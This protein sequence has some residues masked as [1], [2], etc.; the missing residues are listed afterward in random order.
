[1]GSTSSLRSNRSIKDLKEINPDGTGEASPPSSPA[2][3][4]PS[5]DTGGSIRGQAPLA[6]PIPATPGTPHAALRNFMVPVVERPSSTPS[7]PFRGSGSMWDSR[8]G[9]PTPT[10]TSKAPPVVQ[11]KPSALSNSRSFYG[12]FDDPIPITGPTS[13]TSL[14]PPPSINGTS[15]LPSL[16]TP[17]SSSLLTSPTVSN[18]STPIPQKNTRTPRELYNYLREHKIILLDVRERAE[19]EKGHIEPGKESKGVAWV[20]VEPDVLR[21]TE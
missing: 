13:P 7:T 1:M 15:P 18:F 3:G 8:P 11:N 19:F 10:S 20:C 14:D 4:I 17:S 21:R 16:T 6:S 5:T 12:N 9:S 2:S